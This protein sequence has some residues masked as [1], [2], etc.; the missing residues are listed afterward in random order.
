[1]GGVIQRSRDGSTEFEVSTTEDGE[2][3]EKDVN[4]G[5]NQEVT[6]KDYSGEEIRLGNLP[7]GDRTLKS[8]VT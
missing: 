1:M 2:M 8:N 6:T 4:K 3:D 5:G 7:K